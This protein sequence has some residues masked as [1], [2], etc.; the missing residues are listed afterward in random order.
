MD[1]IYSI[2]PTERQAQRAIK[3]LVN[4]EFSAANIYVLMRDPRQND[5]VQDVPVRTKTLVGPGVAIG[6]T[7]GAIGGALVAVSGGLL[8]AGPLVALFQGAVGGGAAGT[9]AGT[10]GGLGYW[11]DV[12]DFPARELESGAILVGVDTDAQGQVHRAGKALLA[13]GA[14]AV[15]VRP[16]SEA[17]EDVRQA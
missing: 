11:R 5:Q 13:A 15:H 10:V 1:L 7:L 9:L 12:A 3:T 4:N 14:D 16:F 17:R 2:F 8:A 6:A